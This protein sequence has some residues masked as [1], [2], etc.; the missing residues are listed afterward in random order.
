MKTRQAG[1]DSGSAFWSSSGGCT[2]ARART[3]KAPS[4]LQRESFRTCLSVCLSLL[5]VTKMSRGNVRNAK[6]LTP[7]A[8]K[9]QAPCVTEAR[10]SDDR[11]QKHNAGSF[12]YKVTSFTQVL[13][14]LRKVQVQG[15]APPQ[16]RAEQSSG[17]NRQNLPPKPVATTRLPRPDRRGA[18][19]RTAASRVQGPQGP[20][21]APPSGP[22]R[23]DE[24]PCQ[25][26]ARSPRAPA[27]APALLWSRPSCSSWGNPAL[28]PPSRP[29]SRG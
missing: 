22:S 18:T 21:E 19:R 2:Q 29:G 6:T 28:P 15:P 11:V 20:A 26:G 25:P 23:A 9:P 17:K 1:K 14:S 24:G 16:A 10:A 4:H 13:S 7:E 5:R 12:S 27:R 8:P 3:K